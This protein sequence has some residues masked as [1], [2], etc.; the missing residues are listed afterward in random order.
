R[1]FMYAEDI[2][3]S[4]RIRKAGHKNLYYCGTT[5]LHFKGESTIKDQLYVSRFY[6]AM[7]QYVQKYKPHRTRLYTR[8]VRF[9]ISLATLVS[10]IKHLF[11]FPT[12]RALSKKL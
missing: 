9:G 4:H 11:R 12:R 6:N 7:Q 1:F 10:R 5:V 3:L 8:M 2:D